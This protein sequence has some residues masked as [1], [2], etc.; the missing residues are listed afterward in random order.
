MSISCENEIIESH[1]FRSFTSHRALPRKKEREKF[2]ACNKC[3]RSDT[4]I[5]NEKKCFC[6][7]FNLLPLFFD[8][9]KRYQDEMPKNSHSQFDKGK[10]GKYVCLSENVMR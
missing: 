8:A 6:G 10:G 5:T 2:E 9:V 3:R 7:K 1:I 4:K